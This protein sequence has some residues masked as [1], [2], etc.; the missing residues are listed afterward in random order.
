VLL[1]THDLGE[2]AFLAERI[3]LLHDGKVV[4]SGSFGELLHHPPMPS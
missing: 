4:Q 1:V 2:A 3:T